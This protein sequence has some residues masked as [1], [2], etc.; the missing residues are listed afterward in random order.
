MQFG[1]K[2]EK[3]GS[4]SQL[5]LGSAHGTDVARTVT[6]DGK[7]VSGFKDGFIPAGTPLKQSEDGKY[8]PVAETSD[9]LAGFLLA[10]QSFT[11]VTTSS[12]PRDRPY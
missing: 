2:T 7:K 3:F 9:V 10:D 6:I 1:M 5:W 4:G 11:V 8:E 12:H